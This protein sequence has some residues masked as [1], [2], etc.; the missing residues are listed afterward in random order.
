MIRPELRKLIDKAV[1]DAEF[2]L[3]HSQYKQA[4]DNYEAVLGMKEL[5]LSQDEAFEELSK[6]CSKAAQSIGYYLSIASVAEEELPNKTWQKILRKA[7][8]KRGN[9][10]R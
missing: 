3:K 7:A 10:S 1:R 5:F 2:L 8:K 6:V 9:H 4:V